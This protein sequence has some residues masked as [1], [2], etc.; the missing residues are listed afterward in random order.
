MRLPRHFLDIF[1]Q[2]T[3]RYAILLRLS[4]RRGGRYGGNLDRSR[5]VMHMSAVLM[6][7]TLT[8]RGMSAFLLCLSESGVPTPQS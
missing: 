7:R 4:S 5:W 6:W 1:V 2:S 3:A 8:Q